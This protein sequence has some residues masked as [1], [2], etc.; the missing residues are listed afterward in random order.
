[1]TKC[2][3]SRDDHEALDKVLG[4]AL[5]WAIPLDGDLVLRFRLRDLRRRFADA[6]VAWIE[7]EDGQD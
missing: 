6:H 5:V 3:L 1:M 4:A 2:E 7:T